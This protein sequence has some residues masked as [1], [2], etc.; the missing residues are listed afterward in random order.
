MK[1]YPNR[2]T[3]VHLTYGNIEGLREF[4]PNAICV[5]RDTKTDD[6]KEF[7]EKGGLLLAAACNQ[8]I[9]FPGDECRLNLIPRLIKPNLMSGVVKKRKG[10]EDGESWYSH[11]VV[12]MLIQQTGRSNRSVTD[13]S[14]TVVGDG[15]LKY[16]VKPIRDEIN[17]DFLDSVRWKR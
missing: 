12:D 11:E 16:F 6:I 14:I 7:K 2:N 8:G 1:K 4:F 9:D 15:N 3:M 5:G 17:K 10:L 13:E